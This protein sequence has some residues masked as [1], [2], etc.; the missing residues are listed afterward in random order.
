[1]PEAAGLSDEQMQQIARELCFSE[2]TFVPLPGAGHACRVRIF[3]HV[4]DLVVEDGELVVGRYAFGGATVAR[5]KLTTAVK[6]F[7]VMPRMFNL[8]GA[9]AGAAQAAPASFLILPRWPQSP[10][11]PPGT[12]S[13]LGG[14]PG[15]SGSLSP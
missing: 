6:V 11:G 1:M 7:A 9:S 14:G 8:E 15:S 12:P 5:E 13:A 4:N 2:T 3:T 10:S